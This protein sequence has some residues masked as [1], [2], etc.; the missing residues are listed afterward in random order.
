MDGRFNLETLLF[1]LFF[2]LESLLQLDLG[3]PKFDTKPSLDS[4]NLVTAYYDGAQKEH[5]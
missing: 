1:R 3:L 4:R 2:N 5:D